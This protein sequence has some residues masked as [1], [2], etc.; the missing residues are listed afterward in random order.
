MKIK[1]LVV[2]A[3]TVMRCLP[4]NSSDVETNN[5][6]RFK[7]GDILDYKADEELMFNSWVTKCGREIHTEESTY[8]QCLDA[9]TVAIRWIGE[10][11]P[12]CE[13]VK[14]ATWEVI[15]EEMRTLVRL[16]PAS[17]VTQSFI[18]KLFGVLPDNT[19]DT[20]EGWRDWINTLPEPKKK[21]VPVNRTADAGVSYRL[22][23]SRG[24]TETGTCDYSVRFTEVATITI[25]EDVVAEAVAADDTDIINDWISDNQGETYNHSNEDYGDYDYDDHESNDTDPDGDLESENRHVSTIMQEYIDN[26]PQE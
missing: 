10:D 12:S 6:L 24:V 3:D 19:I 25:P 17:N 2:I 16:H 13:I 9:G 21:K 23:L 26:H 4:I 22:N 1:Q 8:L 14:P 7:Q 15:P 5:L 20:E 18:V 11:D